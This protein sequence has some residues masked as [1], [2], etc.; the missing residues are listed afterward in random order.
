MDH[1]VAML[2]TMIEDADGHLLLDASMAKLAFHMIQEGRAAPSALA[3]AHALRAA[4]GAG[5]VERLPAFRSA[6]M[7]AVIQAR[8]DLAGPLVAYR[9]ATRNLASKLTSVD[10]ADPSM[11]YEL[12][13]LWRD[14]VQPSLVM[15]RRELSGTRLVRDAALELGTD[16]KSIVAGAAGAAVVFGVGTI[17]DLPG[18]ASAGMAAGSV[19]AQS[20]ARTVKESLKR[21]EAARGNDLFYLYAANQKIG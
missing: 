15:L 11:H 9:R 6:S 18:W 16:A 3:N 1:Y 19:V 21:K 10:L 14:E 2:K 7:I 13:D 12:D 20:V 17:T 5:M 8:A 4:T